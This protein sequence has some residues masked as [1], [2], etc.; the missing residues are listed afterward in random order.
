MKERLAESID[1]R[2]RVQKLCLLRECVCE[3]VSERER[4]VLVCMWLC[5][6]GEKREKETSIVL[7]VS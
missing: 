7:S 2:N 6:Y 5:S 4:E 1:T 3:C